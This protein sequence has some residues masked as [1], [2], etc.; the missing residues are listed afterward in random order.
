MTM[1][2]LHDEAFM[3]EALTEA[4]TALQRGD[5]PIGAIVVHGDRVVA[6]ASN[7][8]TSGQSDVAHAELNAILSC[9]SYLQQHGPDCVIY[10]TCEPCV[11]CLGAII[12]AN[13]REIVFGMPDNYIQG[14]LVIDSV[15]YIKKRVR[16][17]TGGV[18]QEA[19][20]ALFR[21]FS[22]EETALCLQGT[23]K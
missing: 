12:M 6:R 16:R 7:S 8:F 2:L 3:R 21:C 20:I 9:T 10:T 17:Y 4:E 19:C 5:R 22:E 1:P 13:I 11:M 15:P 23:L 14:R 18:L